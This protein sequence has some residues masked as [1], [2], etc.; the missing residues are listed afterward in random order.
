MDKNTAR[1]KSSINPFVAG[2]EAAEQ[3]GPNIVCSE[4]GLMLYVCRYCNAN[5]RDT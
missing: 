4:K 1:L 3:V 5:I 2:V